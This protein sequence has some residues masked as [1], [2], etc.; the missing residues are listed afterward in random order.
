MSG[1]VRSTFSFGFKRKRNVQQGERAGWLNA[2][3][4]YFFIALFTSVHLILDY[5]DF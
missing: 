2:T 1:D 4:K 5:L 3:T